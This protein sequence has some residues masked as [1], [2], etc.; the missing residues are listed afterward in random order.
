MHTKKS[1]HLFTTTIM[2]AGTKFP[3]LYLQIASGQ[4]T[5]GSYTTNYT[6][7]LAAVDY[8]V[9]INR[10]GQDNIRLL[11]GMIQGENDNALPRSL[12]LAGNGYRF[13]SEYQL[14]AWGGF[15]TMLPFSYFSNQF[16]SVFYR[17]DFDR[18][19]YNHKYSKPSLS[20]AHNLTYGS[21]STKSAAADA[22]SYSTNKRLSRI[23]F[24]YQQYH[25]P[26]LSEHSLFQSQPR[27]FLSLD[28][29]TFRLE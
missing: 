5:S 27:W 4:L 9:H 1:E 7:V 24:D 15:M 18:Y 8:K 3:I 12:L 23:R 20:I 22:G 21:L 6:R 2:S 17:H 14:Y 25:P 16:A 29:Y 10:W 11:G 26:Q 28:K 19:F 13:N